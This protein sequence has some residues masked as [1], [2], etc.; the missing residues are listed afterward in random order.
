MCVMFEGEARQS[1]HITK[2]M[3]LDEVAEHCRVDIRTVRRW[4]AN[5]LPVRDL[6][7]EGARPIRRVSLVDLEAWLS[8]YRSVANPQSP[9]HLKL[10]KRKFIKS[11]ERS[12]L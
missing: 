2:L 12:V 9:Q 11:R 5:G 3:K 8:Q 6:P 7:G 10:N 1:E 4:I